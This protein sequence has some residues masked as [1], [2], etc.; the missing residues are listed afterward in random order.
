M[1]IEVKWLQKDLHFEAGNEEGGKIR[2]DGD[3]IVGGLEGGM[4][5]M[6]LLIAGIA[7]CSAIDVINIL[8]K[9]RQ[10]LEDLKV[11]VD[12]DKQKLDT[13]YSEFKTIHLHFILSGELDPKKV[14][15]ALELSITKYCS[16]SKVLEKTSKISYDYEIQD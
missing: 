14:E 9:Q 1:K 7:G 8:E 4:S 16:V 11:E 3:R 5:P 10:D 15:R 6:Q 2:I 12:A 13:G